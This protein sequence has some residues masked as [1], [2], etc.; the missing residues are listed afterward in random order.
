MATDVLVRKAPWSREEEEGLAHAHAQLGNRWSQIARMLPGRNEN[1][2]KN[3]WHSTVRGKNITRAS[4]L[5]MAYVRAA[6]GCCDTPE[7][8]LAALE[9]AQ[10]HVAAELEAAAA[11]EAAEEGVVE[12]AADQLQPLTQPGYAVGPP[13]AS[14]CQLLQTH[15]SLPLASSGGAGSHMA[16]PVPVTAGW[17]ALWRDSSGVIGWPAAADAEELDN[18]CDHGCQD[19]LVPQSRPQGRAR[20]DTGYPTAGPADAVGCHPSVCR[21]LSIALPA[22][23]PTT[24]AAAAAGT[25]AACHSATPYGTIDFRRLDLNGPAP[26]TPTAAP[27]CPG[28]AAAAAATAQARAASAAACCGYYSVGPAP[29]AA[30]VA[31]SGESWNPLPNSGAGACSRA[32]EQWPHVQD[33]QHPQEVHYPT[34]F[35]PSTSSF[36]PAAAAPGASAGGGPYG[37][38]DSPAAASSAVFGL[39]PRFASQPHS[40]PTCPDYAAAAAASC[41]GGSGLC[42]DALDV[43]LDQIDKMDAAMLAGIGPVSE[44]AAGEQGGLIDDALMAELGPA[45]AEPQ[46]AAQAAV[47]QPLL[48]APASTSQQAHAMQQLRYPA[49]CLTAPAATTFSSGGSEAAA[50]QAGASAGAHTPRHHPAPC[51]VTAGGLRVRVQVDGGLQPQAPHAPFK[52]ASTGAAASVALAA[53]PCV[54]P[55]ARPHSTRVGGGAATST[56]SCFD[57]FEAASAARRGQQ[58][59]T[60]VDGGAPPRPACCGTPTASAASLSAFTSGSFGLGQGLGL[61]LGG[62]STTFSLLLGGGGG[63]SRCGSTGPAGAINALQG[64]PSRLGFLPAGADPQAAAA[65]LSH[66]PTVAPG[67]APPLVTDAHCTLGLGEADMQQLLGSLDADCACGAVDAGC[68]MMEL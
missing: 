30:A 17:D 24:T 43:L 63:G 44:A 58:A 40:Q 66:F 38:I 60:S 5:L 20:T 9:A 34:C 39:P 42:F 33:Q 3:L 25:A 50:Q 64:R 15:A 67:T 65:V 45:P 62:S 53:S 1:D 12:E 11:A 48:Q 31:A 26:A 37:H 19:V 16:A 28:V 41:G 32:S 23:A 57:I 8:R 18:G 35:S 52:W 46:P 22:T 27:P 13:P 61:G 55:A 6:A 2:C 68:V 10:R 14:K 59:Q 36:V 21:V 51:P 29:A 56:T 7:A 47:P 49:T 54:S 4:P